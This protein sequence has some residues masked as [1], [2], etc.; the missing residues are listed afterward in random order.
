[1]TTQTYHA[2]SR[3]LLGQAR[4]EL[5]AGDVRQASE[6]GWGAAAQMV[7]AISEKRERE[8]RSHKALF[9]TVDLLVVET[10]DRRIHTTFHS[11]NSLHA[12]F[13]ENWMSAEMVGEGLDE[14]EQFVDLL[15]PL[16]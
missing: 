16:L 14:I 1:M 3:E 7:K 6:K 15:E 10:R 13:Y 4:V 9:D 5:A 12:N 11:A 8:H 2:A